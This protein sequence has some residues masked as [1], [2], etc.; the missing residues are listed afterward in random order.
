MI[1]KSHL[2][3]MK[4]VESDRDKEVYVNSGYISK[5]DMVSLEKSWQTIL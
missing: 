2:V 3:E 1:P 5:E 4:P